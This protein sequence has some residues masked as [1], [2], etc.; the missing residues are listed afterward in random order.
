MAIFE[1]NSFLLS[2]IESNL[3]LHNRPV[4]IYHFL[5]VIKCHNLAR[6]TLK[7]T[8]L[9]KTRHFLQYPFWHEKRKS[10][11]RGHDE[12]AVVQKVRNHCIESLEKFNSSDESFF[13][14]SSMHLNRFDGARFVRELIETMKQ[15]DTKK[16]NYS[17]GQFKNIFPQ[18]R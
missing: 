7:K 14:I 16:I 1:L 12:L 9:N 15:R 5:F 10:R 8:Y 6:F 2:W 18:I 13:M 11:P 17:D 4:L 3:E